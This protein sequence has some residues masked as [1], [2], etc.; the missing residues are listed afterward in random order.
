[1]FT[2]KI[3]PFPTCTVI[4]MNCHLRVELFKN[5][6]SVLLQTQC[7]EPIVLLLTVNLALEN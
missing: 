2:N 7:D 6:M 5:T 3:Q 1:M 4:A